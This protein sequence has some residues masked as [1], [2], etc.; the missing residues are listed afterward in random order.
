MRCCLPACCCYCYT[1]ETRRNGEKKKMKKKKIHFTCIYPRRKRYLCSLFCSHGCCISVK[2][3]H[4]PLCLYRCHCL[5]FDRILRFSLMFSLESTVV[6]VKLPDILIQLK[7]RI[8]EKNVDRRPKRRKKNRN[9]TYQC[10]RADNQLLHK[11]CV[12]VLF[13]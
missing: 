7:Q 4:I 6:T 13:V 8:Q 9:R 2:S 12:S 11:W 1:T 5:R 10:K 3:Y